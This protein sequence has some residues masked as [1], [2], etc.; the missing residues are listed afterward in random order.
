MSQSGYLFL[1]LTAIVAAL[2][3]VLAYAVLRIFAAA[4]AATRD[5][6]KAGA[7]TAFMAAAMED[8]VRKLRDG[9]R[10]MK[11][12]AEASERLSSEI[13]ASLT[14]GLLVVDGEG[15]VRTLNPAGQ[16]ML[17][18]T[19][20][21]WEGPYRE[22][23]KDA[24]PLADVLEEC[25]TTGKPV[26]RRAVP[27]TGGTA[28]HLGLTVSPIRGE[29]GGTG[30]GVICLFTD[31]T[32]VMELEDQLRLKDSLARLGE[33]TAGI[34][35]EFRN[36]L[37]TIH[38]YG[39]LIDLERLPADYRPYVQG[40]RDETEALGQVVT[41]FLGFARP[42]ELALA[43]VEMAALAERAAD[44]VRAEA[45][46]RGGD[47]IVRGDFG[48][49]EGDEV[50]LRQAMSNLCRNAFEACDQAKVSPTI[51][52]EGQRDVVHGLLRISVSDN[53][54]GVPDDIGD[55]VFRPF[56]TTKAQGTGL[57][58]ALVQK[59]IVTH[60]GRVTVGN[61]DG[62]GA[63][64]VVTLPASVGVTEHADAAAGLPR[65]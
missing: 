3:A 46:V 57:G 44:E 12:R 10:A 21:R 27:L 42:T 29:G 24:G 20:S 63:R 13:V 59:I 15:I 39:R 52:I 54:P 62:G 41:N 5:D 6:R 56:F 64:F 35:H 48:R 31:L 37:A 53:G 55:R 50:L 16:S 45:R 38:G 2:S 32:E 19:G 33:M 34:A 49:V 47:V 25:L 11:A 23:L 40:I 9:E 60:N 30:Q 26:V 17:G 7:E 8:A 43:P 61:E 22:V 14:S 18:L 4:R 28:S 65:S 58:L 51:V 1:G 36:G